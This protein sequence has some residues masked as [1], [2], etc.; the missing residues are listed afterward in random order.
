[1]NKAATLGSIVDS[2]SVS[3]YGLPHVNDH[4]QLI[5]T[6]V[7]DF[8]K[9]PRPDQFNSLALSVFAFQFEKNDAY[10]RFCA[11]RNKTPSNVNSWKTI[12]AVPTVA[13]KELDLCCGP[14]ERVFLTSGTTEG[15]EKRGRHLLTNMDLYQASSMS[16]FG[17]CVTPDQPPLHFLNLIPSPGS[18]PY[19][20]LALMAEWAAKNFGT[21]QARWFIDPEGI[22][23]APFAL[24]LERA[25]RENQPVCILGIT[26]A[27]VAFFDWCSSNQKIFALPRGSRIMDTG[28]NKGNTRNISRK[29][30]L[31]A[32]WK[33]LKVPGYYCVNEYGMTEMCS[34][35][36]DHVL[37]S[38]SRKSNEPR[39]KIGPAWARTLVVNAETLDELPPGERGILRHVDLANCGSVSAI[40]TDDVGYTTGDGFEIVGRS[41]GAEARGC[42][43]M[44]D[45]FLSAQ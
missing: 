33:Y 8:I 34:Q 45:E 17:Q 35:F 42:A 14:P 44:L 6:R 37:Y 13:F 36:Y 39:Y 23:L 29:G 41:S 26:S 4:K 10:R 1:M 28:G 38:R 9:E 7:L 27:L 11:S 2:R 21:T 18:Q 43:L 40:Q 19:S 15:K 24:A 16:H 3:F 25:E 20:S 32:C 30:F 12:P 5:E 31:Q 22:H